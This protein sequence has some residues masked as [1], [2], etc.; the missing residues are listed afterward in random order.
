MFKFRKMR[1]HSDFVSDGDTVIEK[2]FDPSY[3]SKVIAVERGAEV[4][5]ERSL[6]FRV[7]SII[8][9]GADDGSYWARY[10]KIDNLTSLALLQDGSSE[11]SQL[12]FQCGQALSLI[13]A[14]M[15]IPLKDQIWALDWNY[16]PEEKICVH[17]DFSTLNV[18]VGG[19]GL[20]IWDWVPARAWGFYANY[21]P[22][23]VDFATF[24][25]TLFMYGDSFLRSIFSFRR[26][27]ALFFTGYGSF[28]PR[29]VMVLGL[30]QFSKRV[31]VDLWKR[32]AYLASV[33]NLCGGMFCIFQVL[34]WK[35]RV[36][37]CENQ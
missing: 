2:R 27:M 18:G 11:F 8:D 19:D 32:R 21:G 5:G 34:L 16:S 36:D 13:H 37:E 25:F 15:E 23:S 30:F 1:G 17:G 29:K 10:K 3:G 22:A 7:P 26:W 33:A 4:L 9:A 6:L 24:L 35:G 28:P 31:A 20:Y 12:I 14:Q